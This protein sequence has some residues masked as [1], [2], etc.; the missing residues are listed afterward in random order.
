MQIGE[1]NQV[2]RGREQQAETELAERDE[3]CR[4]GGM[5]LKGVM[6][7]TGGARKKQLIGR[8]KNKRKKKQGGSRSLYKR[9][10]PLFTTMP[11][12]L[13]LGKRSNKILGSFSHQKVLPS[14]R[15]IL[16]LKVCT[17]RAQY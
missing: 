6:G 10:F 16:E 5:S 2:N 12:S 7:L 14:Y 11:F 15:K 3:R 8:R 17:Q 4:E 9:E 1:V 13:L